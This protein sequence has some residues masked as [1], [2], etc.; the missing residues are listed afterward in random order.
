MSVPR[1]KP[2]F[3]AG[4]PR[5]S[6]GI[7]T[8][9]VMYNRGGDHSFGQ[10][11]GVGVATLIYS[12]PGRLNSVLTTQLGI[13]GV[14]TIFYDGTAATSGGPFATSGHKILCIIPPLLTA[15]AGSGTLNPLGWPGVL[16]YPDMPFNSGL[17][18]APTLS[19]SHGF[20]CS[21]T[22]ESSIL[23]GGSIVGP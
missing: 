5:S 11:S 19:G 12:G 15:L 14:A 7:Q 22:P 2:Q 20:S 9:E 13:S 17:Y 10:I 21:F 4:S 16:Q 3:V 8:G 18:V 1:S 6:G 23:D